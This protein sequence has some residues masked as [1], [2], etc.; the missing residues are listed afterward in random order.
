MPESTPPPPPT[1]LELRKR[2][3]KEKEKKKRKALNFNPITSKASANHAA[4]SAVHK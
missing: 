2:K 4:S 1:Q 3:K